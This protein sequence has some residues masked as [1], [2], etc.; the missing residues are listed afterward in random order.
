LATVAGV[1][2]LLGTIIEGGK[3][4]NAIYGGVLI[5]PSDEGTSIL[6]LTTLVVM[7]LASIVRLPVSLMQAMV[8]VALAVGILLETG[9]KWSF[10]I[11]VASSWVA[12]PL[13]AAAA[14]IVIYHA[15]KRTG[16]RIGN[17]FQRAK[18]YAIITLGG[19][20]Y[21]GYALGANGVGLVNGI[22]QSTIGSLPM[23]SVFL[24]TAAVLGIYVFGYRVTRTV[25][26]R[27]LALTGAAALAAQLGG[28]L[29]VHL[30]TQ[31][32]VPVSIT[33]AIIG[34]ITGIAQAKDIAIVNRRIVLHIILGWIIAPLTGIG[35][36]WL[37]LTLS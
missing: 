24:S 21:V 26:E 4:S 17:I 1:G 8:G 6:F 13:V 34:G 16:R 9:V 5:N 14:S 15:V 7:V 30:F 37:I 10:V 19:S 31:F 3:L 25:S 18:V 32:G 12:T 29:T 27:I 23:F 20:F 11:L 28:A 2:A 35:L 36:A 22:L 33:Q